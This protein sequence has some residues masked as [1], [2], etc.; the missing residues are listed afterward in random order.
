[1]TTG[2]R[3]GPAIQN[4]TDAGAEART[5]MQQA[6]AGTISI[7]TAAQT[8]ATWTS[9][10]ESIGGC[11]C[12]N[13][14]CQVAVAGASLAVTADQSTDTNPTVPGVSN[15]GTCGAVGGASLMPFM[16]LGWGFVR[17]NARRK[18]L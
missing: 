6:F 1:M 18:S 12:N 16:L 5:L 14:G 3:L 11:P 15:S 7:C 2:V 17:R 4:A 8:F 10:G 13:N 9:T